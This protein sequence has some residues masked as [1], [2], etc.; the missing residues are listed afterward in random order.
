M[1]QSSDI[2]L[3]RMDAVSTDGWMDGILYGCLISHLFE[4]R[5]I[6][7]SASKFYIQ[8]AREAQYSCV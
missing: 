5:R 6:P 2:G 1:V 4:K 7:A 8:P 3:K